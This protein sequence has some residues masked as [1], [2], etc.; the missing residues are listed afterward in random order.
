MKRLIALAVFLLLAI[1]APGY[2]FSEVDVL[3]FVRWA[4]CNAEVATSEAHAPFASHYHPIASNDQYAYTLHIGTDP[5]Y[6]EYL[7]P[8]LAH[9]V[10]HCLQDQAGELP[11]VHPDVELDADQR[12]AALLCGRGLDGVKMMRDLLRYAQVEFG[13]QGDINHGTIR[14]RQAAAESALACHV[15]PRQA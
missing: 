1:P 11:G 8:I 5:A 13:Y 4:G 6:D 2:S 7:L 3:G 15:L 12:G 9:E 14:M 10:G